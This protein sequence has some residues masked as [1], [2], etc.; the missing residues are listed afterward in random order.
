GEVVMLPRNDEEETRRSDCVVLH[1]I[2]REVPHPKQRPGGEPAR[3]AFSLRGRRDDRRFVI[4]NYQ[5]GHVFLH[6][7]SPLPILRPT[8][9]SM[10]KC[11]PTR[12]IPG[13]LDEESQ[14]ACRCSRR[15]A[16]RAQL[17]FE[18]ESIRRLLPPVVPGRSL[19]EPDRWNDS[20]VV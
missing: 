2:R 15:R 1:P 6:I 17:E 9:A 7:L 12:L 13:C 20:R 8:L 14:L 3:A 19:L 4:A 5:P 18:P 11:D 16:H 10:K